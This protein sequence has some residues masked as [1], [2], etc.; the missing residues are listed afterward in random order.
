MMIVNNFQFKSDTVCCISDIHI[1]VHQN[2]QMWLDICSDW[3]DW[4]IK[5]LK[6]KKIK[7]IVIAGDLFHY[8]DEI[9]VNTIHHVSD[10]LKKFDKFNIIMLVGNH[11]AFY[12]DRSDVNSMS[13]LSGWKNIAVVQDKVHTARISQNLLCPMGSYRRRHPIV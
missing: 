6:K 9:A 8:R 11:D 10:F 3:G 12:K 7:D 4:L 1:G 2:S 13:I 5:E